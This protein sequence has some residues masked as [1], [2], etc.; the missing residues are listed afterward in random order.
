MHSQLQA[1]SPLRLQPII[2]FL[3]AVEIP[4][5]FN[6]IWRYL[7]LRQRI[8]IG[9]RM[10]ALTNN[11]SL[12]ILP[13]RQSPFIN[14]IGILVIQPPELIIVLQLKTLLTSFQLLVRTRS[15]TAT[16]PHPVVSATPLV[17]KLR[18]PLF[19]LQNLEFHL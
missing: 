16:L 4:P 9:Y 13:S 5:I 8:F 11:F 6:L 12:E 15:P 7:L 10:V 14:G 18:S 19:Q 17:N 2:V 3:M 1:H